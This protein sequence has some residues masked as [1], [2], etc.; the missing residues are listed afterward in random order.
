MIRCPL[1]GEADCRPFHRDAVRPYLRCGCCAL[2]FVPASHHVDR[3]AERARYDH[4]RNNPDDAGYVAFLSR[5]AAPL[6]RLLP[7][8]AAGLDFGCGPAPVLADML[9]SG[10]RPT[11]VYD[12]IYFP[13][14]SVWLSRYDFVTATEVFEHLRDP[15]VELRR[16]LGIL[17]PHGLLAIMTGFVPEDPRALADWHYLR[18]ATHVAFYSEATFTFIAERWRASIALMERD[19]VILRAA[20]EGSGGARQPATW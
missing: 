5:L 10:G 16:L 15:A 20:G 6:V 17:R 13:D 1:C 7:P 12:P 14:E 3:A 18:D 11:A 8:G 4:H 2:V 9:S 19:V